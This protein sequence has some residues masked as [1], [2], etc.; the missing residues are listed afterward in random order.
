M[1]YSQLIMNACEK[2]C[3]CQCGIHCT[4]D[5]NEFKGCEATPNESTCICMYSLPSMCFE[6]LIRKGDLSLFITVNYFN[7]N[8]KN[9]MEKF[10]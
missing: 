4:T 8:I 1:L 9:D 3:L 2:N 5:D 10:Q 7:N 6:N